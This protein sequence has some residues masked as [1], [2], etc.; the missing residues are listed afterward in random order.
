MVAFNLY[1]LYQQV[2]DC[3]Q[4]PDTGAGV[5]SDDRSLRCNITQ[6]TVLVLLLSLGM[7]A[8]LLGYKVS[9][10]PQLQSIWSEKRELNWKRKLLAADIH[11]SEELP[12]PLR[13]PRTPRTPQ[14]NMRGDVGTPRPYMRDA[15]EMAN[16]QDIKAETA[17]DA[18]L[19]PALEATDQGLVEA[20]KPLYGLC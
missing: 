13:T 15:T 18:S 7:S 17:D 6:R 1:F 12:M 19:L 20:G 3:L 10:L 14:Q 4:D 16:M 11:T 9:H 5:S 2:G 8:V